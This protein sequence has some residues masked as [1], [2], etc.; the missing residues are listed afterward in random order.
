MTH[1]C[2]N[3][4]YCAICIAEKKQKRARIVRAAIKTATLTVSV[5]TRKK[6]QRVAALA[7]AGKNLALLF[8]ENLEKESKK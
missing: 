2:R 8:L 4:K 6:L 3:P 1:T 5:S 7:D